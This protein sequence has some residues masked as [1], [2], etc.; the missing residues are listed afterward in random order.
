MKDPTIVPHE[1]FPELLNEEAELKKKVARS[2]WGIAKDKAS[3][4][5]SM[6]KVQTYEEAFQKIKEATEITDIDELVSKFVD[7]E[8]HN[9]QLQNYVQELQN[10]TESL[11]KEIEKIEEEIEMYK[12]EGLTAE[13]QRNDII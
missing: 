9:Q 7:A 1:S 3:I 10:E 5:V 13:N 2:S 8:R 4:H 12:G 11:D 6:E